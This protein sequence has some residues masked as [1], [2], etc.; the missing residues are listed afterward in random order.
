MYHFC[1]T[2]I[3]SIVINYIG[4]FLKGRLK[5]IVNIL[6]FLKFRK[7]SLSLF[8]FVII[9]LF[10]FTNTGLSFKDRFTNHIGMEFILVQPGTFMMGSPED[11]L[12]RD[13]NEVL[14]K[15]TIPN[16]F[17]LTAT[18]VT[19]KQWRAVMGR[20]WFAKK[21][22]GNN[23]PVTKVS[24]YEAERFI[25]KFN[26]QKRGVYRLPTE[27]EW[28]YACRAGT[29]TAYCWGEK[30]D[31]SKAMYQNNSKK[32]GDCIL[33]YKSLG[34]SANQ[35]APVKSF[36]PNAWGFYDMHGNVWEWCSDYYSEYKDDIGKGNYDIINAGTR[37]KRGGS[38]YKYG[39]YLRSANRAYAHPAGKF[40]TTG[41]RLVLEAD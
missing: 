24:F 18:E 14:H 20:K 2:A 17:Y 21:T 10:C 32:C 26:G 30:I 29:A 11:E 6:S 33:Y 36:Q 22:G 34:L 1:L 9:F 16:A 31:C 28:E 15:V 25:R 35:A 41:F 12:H 7:K 37:V 19:V 5:S 4:H 27:A 3:Y 39:F 40:Q 38:W 8:L 23:F 13:K